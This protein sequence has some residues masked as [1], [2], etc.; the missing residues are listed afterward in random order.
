MFDY[1]TPQYFARIE[2]GFARIDALQQSLA[3]KYGGVTG[4]LRDGEKG[5]VAR[6]RGRAASLE[7]D[8]RHALLFWHRKGKW[9]LYVVD[10]QPKSA[11]DMVKRVED[12]PLRVRI[13][14]LLLLSDLEHQLQ[15]EGENQ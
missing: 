4:A 7:L 11:H 10:A 14:T 2:E 12:A 15:Y 1:E 13:S 5:L 6:Y 3:E 9:G 8:G